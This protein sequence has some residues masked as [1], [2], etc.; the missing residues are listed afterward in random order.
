VGTVRSII[1]TLL[2]LVGAVA[3]LAGAW[4]FDPLLGVVLGG[5]ALIG[6][7]YIIADPRHGRPKG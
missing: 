3:I 5:C 7:G 6:A 4:A 2:E 1:G